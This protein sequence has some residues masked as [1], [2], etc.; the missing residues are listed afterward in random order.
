MILTFISKRLALWEK[1]RELRKIDEHLGMLWDQL[2]SAKEGIR[3][4]EAKKQRIEEQIAA[5]EPPD[6]L[7]RRISA[8]A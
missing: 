7:V 8:G 6:D 3:R 5:I 4:Y 2:L 1:R